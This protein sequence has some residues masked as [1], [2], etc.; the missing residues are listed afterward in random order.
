MQTTLKRHEGERVAA[1]CPQPS[2][3][4]VAVVNAQT[5][6]IEFNRKHGAILHALPERDFPEQD[7]ERVRG[8]IR[9]SLA[10]A[11]H[12]ARETCPASGENT[13]SRPGAARLLR[14]P[15]RRRRLG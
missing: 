14:L 3:D 7:D 9:A 15:V 4:K 10:Q 1:Q 12:G 6:A 13:S 5:A 11:A 8:R 2:S